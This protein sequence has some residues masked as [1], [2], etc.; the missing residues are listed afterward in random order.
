MKIA[1]VI[2]E[3]NPF[4]SGHEWH[5]AETRRRTGCDFVVVCMAGSY[6]QR[7]EAACLSKW[8]RA[9]AALRCGADAV[10]EL[11]ALFAVRSAD[12]FARGGVGVLDGLGVDAL[13]FGC[14]TTRLQTIE[15]LAELREYEPE[16]LSDAVRRG[17]AEGKS[18]AR[19][20]GEAVA[21]MLG[22]KPEALN[23]PNL[24]LAA[25]YVRQLRRRSSAM[26]IAVVPRAGDYHDADVR[27]PFASATAVRAALAE[28]RKE[29]ALAAVPEAAREILSRA[30]SMHAPDDLLLWRLRQT[31]EA[32]LSALPG[33]AEGL[34]RRI[35]RCASGAS[36]REE[37][38]DALKC[39]RYT[40]ARLS[41]ILA[42]ALLGLT[43]ALAERHP[44]PE[45]ARLMGMRRDARPLLSELKRRAKLP[46]VS[47]PVRLQSD[48]CF[49]L[50][51]RATDL[52]AL[53]CDDP[54]ERR[55]G[56]ELT[57]KFVMV[58]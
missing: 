7:G 25:E 32:E 39:K 54:S 4:H 12:A 22:M 49:R 51:C 20:R 30:G 58:E 43:N 23:A 34:E 15:A 8:A 28:G 10:F 6:V 37:L 16:A 14:E 57:R 40:R 9:E 29:E 13:S 52:R 41:R 56:Q 33:V 47:D 53:Q 42:C 1:G 26:E 46:I 44:E 3:Y 38:L 31:S 24:V 36:T 18:H 35:L 45:Y 5:L 11:P 21:A 17:L 19:A 2:A 27:A 55:A 50:E 48:E